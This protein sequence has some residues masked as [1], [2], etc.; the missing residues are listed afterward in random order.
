MSGNT[1]KSFKEL[2]LFDQKKAEILKLA[3]LCH[4]KQEFRVKYYNAYQYARNHG[5]KDECFEH[6]IPMTIAEAKDRAKMYPSI[7]QFKS[8][9]SR[10]Y[11]TLN[12]AGILDEVFNE[13]SKDM[14]SYRRFYGP[15]ISSQ[16]DYAIECIKKVEDLFVLNVGAI[17]NK[18]GIPNRDNKTVQSRNAIITELFAY[19]MK[20]NHIRFSMRSYKQ[21]FLDHT[22]VLHA[23]DRFESDYTYTYTKE[24][25]ERADMI[26][27]AMR[28]FLG[29]KDKEVATKKNEAMIPILGTVLLITKNE[30]G[31]FTANEL[32][33]D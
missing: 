13:I 8:N 20:K 9:Q 14:T 12:K 28:I 2:N 6:L 21:E 7:K 10:A 26:R 17:G 4:T 19:G 25:K 23:L 22:T 32:T 30:D 27:S 33:N 3:A 15:E 24:E 5:F 11:E 29:S 31:T 18:R 1:K 16:I